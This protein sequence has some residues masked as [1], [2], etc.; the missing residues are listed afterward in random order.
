MIKPNTI[1]KHKLIVD[2]FFQKQSELYAKMPELRDNVYMKFFFDAVAEEF[3]M[4][5]D[6]VARIIR[7]S[8]NKNKIH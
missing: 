6:H 8:L 1:K 4:D 7:K 5:T 3:L 2:R